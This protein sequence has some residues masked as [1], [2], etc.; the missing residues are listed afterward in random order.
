V[1]IEV[2]NYSNASN[3]RRA[4]KAAGLSEFDIY[5]ANDGWYK[6]RVA[7]LKAA[8]RWWSILGVAKSASKEE[9]LGAYRK[10]A[11]VRHPDKGGDGAVMKELNLARDAALKAVDKA[12]KATKSPKAAPEESKAPKAG[13]KTTKGETLFQMI[14]K[15][16]TIT[17]LTASLG[18]QRHTVRAAICRLSKAGYTVVRTKVS[19]TEVCAPAARAHGFESHYKIAA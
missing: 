19:T 15:G 4:A 11:V 12:P 10:L 16:A 8:K 6:I 9:I 13:R 1:T 3:A 14:K 7:A 2:K 5:R 18:W 17:E